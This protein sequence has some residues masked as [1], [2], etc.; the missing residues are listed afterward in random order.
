MSS[1]N[2]AHEHEGEHKTG[3]DRVR[4]QAMGNPWYSTM[5]AVSQVQPN[6]KIVLLREDALTP[7]D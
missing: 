2:D 4:P 5:R 3:A 6:Q 7:W 1:H